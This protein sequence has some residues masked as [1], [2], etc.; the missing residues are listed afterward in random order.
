MAVIMT[1]GWSGNEARERLNKVVW[2]VEASKRWQW[3]DCSVPF[4]P[5]QSVPGWLRGVSW[6]HRRSG[7]WILWTASHLPHLAQTSLCAVCLRG[8][9][10]EGKQEGEIADDILVV[11]QVDT[12]G[13]HFNSNLQGGLHVGVLCQ[14][15]PRGMPLLFSLK[16]TIHDW[17]SRQQW[18][19]LQAPIGEE[20]QQQGTKL[21][22]PLVPQNRPW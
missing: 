18:Q 14:P 11:H 12:V 10:R 16:N 21:P 5:P 13:L 4:L 6:T 20:Y 2:S 15:C 9:K 1:T 3:P 17:T 7:P 22:A 8:Y 19:S